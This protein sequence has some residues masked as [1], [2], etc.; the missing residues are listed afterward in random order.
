M[1]ENNNISEVDNIVKNIIYGK[2][3]GSSILFNFIKSGEKK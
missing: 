1:T 2:N 3:G